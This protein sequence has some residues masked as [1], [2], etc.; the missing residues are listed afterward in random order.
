MAGTKRGSTPVNTFEVDIDLRDATVWVVYTQDNKVVFEKTG[1]DLDVT[2]NEI[3][4]KLTQEETLRFHQGAAEIEVDY[5]FP[6]GTADH[7]EIIKTTFE[8]I[9][10]D[11][12][13]VP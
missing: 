1:S 5:V 3:R 11:E 4:L 6:N 10:K 7:S 13:L 2:E 9:L 8:R 12:V